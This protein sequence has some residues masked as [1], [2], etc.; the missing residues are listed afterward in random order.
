VMAIGLGTFGWWAQAIAAFIVA[1]LAVWS[2]HQFAGEG[3]PGW[4][5]VDEA[6]GMFLATI[7]LIGWSAVVAFFVF[8]AADIE[9]R[10]PGVGTAERLPG[11]WGITADDL[12]AGLYG[13][14]AGWSFQLLVG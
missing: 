8:R 1:G 9:K 5:V 13:L 6:A 11:G 12:V 2:A 10:T 4:V 7:G 3:D 14:A